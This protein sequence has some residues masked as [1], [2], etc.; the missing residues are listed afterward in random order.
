MK[1]QKVET[2]FE[3]AMYAVHSPS[4][5]QLAEDIEWKR[6]K[7]LRQN[8]ARASRRGDYSKNITVTLDELYQIGEK[9]GWKC[10]LTGIPLE[11][12]RGGDYINNS[13]PNSCTIDRDL[14]YIGYTRYNVQLTTWRVNAIKNHL[15]TKEF[16]ELCKMVTNHVDSSTK[17]V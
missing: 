3:T 12:T 1:K 6:L 17:R 7:H 14:N 9:Q 2:I 11:F 8:L 5:K 10:A 4:R 16:V 15:S 13:N